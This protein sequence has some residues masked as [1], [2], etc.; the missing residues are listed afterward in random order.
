MTVVS[1]AVAPGQVWEL[2]LDENIDLETRDANQAS[3]SMNQVR[4][5][6]K[7]AR[8]RWIKALNGRG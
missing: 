7:G 6:Q 1:E 5:G 2:A 8:E 3:V 4:R